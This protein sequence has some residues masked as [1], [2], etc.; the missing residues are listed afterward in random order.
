MR[1]VIVT[2]FVVFVTAVLVIGCLLFTI[3]VRGA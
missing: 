3:A 2:R 1:H